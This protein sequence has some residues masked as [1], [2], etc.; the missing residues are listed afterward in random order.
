MRTFHL[1]CPSSHLEDLLYY[2]VFLYFLTFASVGIRF[3]F[4]QRLHVIWLL[5]LLYPVY[6]KPLTH[7][8]HSSNH[9]VGSPVSRLRTSTFH[10]LPHRDAIETAISFGSSR[11]HR[12]TAS[13]LCDLDDL[14]VACGPTARIGKYGQINTI[15]ALEETHRRINIAQIWRQLGVIRD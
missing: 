11:H 4:Y 3:R 15:I 2:S 10:V 1:A 12:T 14:D 13:S 9:F 5:F 7:P 6:S 8:R